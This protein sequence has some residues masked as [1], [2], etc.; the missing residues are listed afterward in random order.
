MLPHRLVH[1]YLS[2]FGGGLVFGDSF[3]VDSVGG[4]FGTSLGVD[5]PSCGFVGESERQINPDYPCWIGPEDWE[6]TFI[7]DPFGPDFTVA[8]ALRNF[9]AD[10]S[11]GFVK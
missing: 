11:S 10:G 6:N 4:T 8:D 7:V 9:V 3:R 5:G 1:P 2:V